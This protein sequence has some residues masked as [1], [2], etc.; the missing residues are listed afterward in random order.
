MITRYFNINVETCKTRNHNKIIEDKK[1]PNCWSNFERLRWTKC[2]NFSSCKLL[3]W[4]GLISLSRLLD[5]SWKE[6]SN[7]LRCQIF[8][9]LIK[10]ANYNLQC[11][12]SCLYFYY[13]PPWR[14][15][16]YC[17]MF[18][19][20]C[21]PRIKAS[22]TISPREVVKEEQRQRLC[23]RLLWWGW[24]W[25]IIWSVL[26]SDEWQVLLSEQRELLFYVWWP[27]VWRAP[28]SW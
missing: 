18:I 21:F 3:N 11:S 12:K 16:S 20:D 23:C 4:M 24:L 7:L 14:R 19:A 17:L 15:V 26:L 1:L 2:S 6:L 13:E 22:M 28:F 10:L 25:I 27:S 5:C 8:N 9:Y